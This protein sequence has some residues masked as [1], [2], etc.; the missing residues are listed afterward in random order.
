MSDAKRAWD[1]V[2]VAPNQNCVVKLP[3]ETIEVRK[4]FTPGPNLHWQ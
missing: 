4:G 2:I 1:I 3:V